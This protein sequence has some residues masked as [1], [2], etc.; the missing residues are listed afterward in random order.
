M[1]RISP[2]LRDQI[3]TDPYYRQCARRHD[4][5]CAGGITIEHATTYAGRQI[6]RLWN[7][8][9]I[10]ERHHSVGHFMDC[11]ALDKGKNRYIALCRASDA[12]LDEFPRVNFRKHK[13]LL[14]RQ[15]GPCGA[16][17]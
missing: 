8:L 5:G 13:E 15:Y 17:V 7:L 12:E 1:R 4:G 14:E 16:E 6:D 11:G 10:C 3:D 9:P 2:Q